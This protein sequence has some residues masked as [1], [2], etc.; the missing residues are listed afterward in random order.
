MIR[1]GPPG[2]EAGDDAGGMQMKG[3]LASL[4][5]TIGALGTAILIAV[6]TS[7]AG[8][9]KVHHDPEVDFTSYKTFAWPEK[10]GLVAARPDVQEVIVRSVDEQLEAKGLRKVDPE[11][12]DLWVVT[13]AVSESWGGTVSGFYRPAEWQVGFITVDSRMVSDGALVV[14]LYDAGK[15]NLIWHAIA[16]ASATSREQAKKKVRSYVDKAF[17]DFPPRAK[18]KE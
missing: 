16:K 3:R 8:G 10:R 15:N 7:H 17:R 13:Y 12:A 2:R 9:L 18:D 6:G 11:E 5:R 4:C 1:H 14:D